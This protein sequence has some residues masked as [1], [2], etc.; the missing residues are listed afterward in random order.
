MA[1]ILL[2]DDDDVFRSM[3]SQTLAHF[4][5]QVTQARNGKE[6]LKFLERESVDLVITDIVMPEK[7]GVEVL[8]ELRE[9]RPAL[10][11]IVISGGGPG[12]AEGY[13]GI[14]KLLGASA[15]LAK[16]FSNEALLTAIGKLLPGAGGPGAPSLKA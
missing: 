2:I 8:M 3:L 6:G 5:H 15:A 11:I 9:Q 1:W 14:A 4:G 7:E 16:P 12:S 10:K 13:L